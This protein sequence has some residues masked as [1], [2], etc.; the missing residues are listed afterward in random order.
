M[1]SYRQFRIVTDKPN[2]SLGVSA[3]QGSNRARGLRREVRHHARDARRDV[4]VGCTERSESSWSRQPRTHNGHPVKWNPSTDAITESSA[5]GH[6]AP[7]PIGMTSAV[8]VRNSKENDNANH[9]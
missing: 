1:S 5:S 8:A 9:R 6:H 4:L 3:S 2:L 7:F